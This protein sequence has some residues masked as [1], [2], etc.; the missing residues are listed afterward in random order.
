M[1]RMNTFTQAQKIMQ[2]WKGLWKLISCGKEKGSLE[3]AGFKIHSLEATYSRA[4][5]LQT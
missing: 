2:E 5:R 4:Q 3:A 1:P